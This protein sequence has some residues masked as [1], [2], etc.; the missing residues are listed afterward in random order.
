MF[1]TTSPTGANTVSADHRILVAARHA[2]YTLVDRFLVRALFADS[3]GAL[4][5]EDAAS[6]LARYQDCT[7]GLAKGHGCAVCIQFALT[8]RGVLEPRALWRP[9]DHGRLAFGLWNAYLGIVATH[10]AV[11]SARAE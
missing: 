8:M 11:N 10:A 4:A 1:H 5:A 2:R 9:A 6:L 3:A 7:C